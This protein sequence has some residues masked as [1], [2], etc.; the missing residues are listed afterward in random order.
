MT[1][2][3]KRLGP[4]DSQRDAEHSLREN[5][6]ETYYYDGISL[7]VEYIPSKVHQV[8]PLHYWQ[9]VVSYGTDGVVCRHVRLCFIHNY[10]D[11]WYVRVWPLAATTRN[12]CPAEYVEWMKK[13]VAV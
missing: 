1:N 4:Y 11:V 6:I 12:D 7:R 13:K 2:Y 5:S 9:C 10:D 3:S 8:G